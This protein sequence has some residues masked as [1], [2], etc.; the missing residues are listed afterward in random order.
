MSAVPSGTALPIAPT[1]TRIA[2]IWLLS[3]IGFYFILPVLGLPV[4]YNAGFVGV[5]TTSP[6]A[7]SSGA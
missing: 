6:S 1:L 3:D 5:A 4:R 7:S 2:G